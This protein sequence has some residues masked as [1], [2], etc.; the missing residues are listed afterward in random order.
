MAKIIL[1]VVVG[2]V[3]IFGGYSLLNS[4]K[5]ATVDPTPSAEVA[6][7]STKP[8]TTGKKMAFADFIKNDSRSYKCE[9][10][11]AMSDFEN[12]GTVYVS[13]GK[14]SGEY[15]TVAEG[16]TMKSSFILR[17]GYS[18]MWTPGTSMGFKVKNST[19]ANGAYSWKAEQV[20]DYNCEAWTL[21]ASKF[22]LPAG[23]TFKEM[24]SVQ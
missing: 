2:A 21:D 6:D 4:K 13:E 18:Y 1:W 3:A 12:S 22:T 23:V 20:G 8:E 10:K 17:D 19:E 16:K 7:D 14:I 11:Q 9:V 24:S 15:S 5:V